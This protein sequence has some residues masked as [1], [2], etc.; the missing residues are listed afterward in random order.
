MKKVR[1]F[2]LIVII[3]LIAFVA[4][5]PV[6]NNLSAKK[7]E[8]QLLSLTSP[9]NTVTVESLSKAGKLIGNGNGMQYFGAML[10]RSERALEDLSAYYSQ[11]NADVIVKEQKTQDIDFLEHE[12]LSF[13][14]N[15]ADG[16]TYY[17]VYLFGG[18]IAPFSQLDIRGH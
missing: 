13:K 8:N 14:S 9:D 17:I 6:V 15:I 16:K 4:S 18:G 1:I 11:Q 3:C 7:I 2:V 10:I 5:V 12:T